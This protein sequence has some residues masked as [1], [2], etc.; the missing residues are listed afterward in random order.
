MTSNLSR[1]AP[2]HRL[3]RGRSRGALSI[4]TRQL[5][6]AEESRP[7]RGDPFVRKEVNESEQFV[8]IHMLEGEPRDFK[9]KRASIKD[10]EYFE[11]MLLTEGDRFLKEGDYTRAFSAI[12]LSGSAIRTGRGLPSGSIASFS[13]KGPRR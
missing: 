1:P 2:C 9:V 12:S 7:R 11:D 13:K 8:I 3:T 5:R 10:V 4:S 6:K